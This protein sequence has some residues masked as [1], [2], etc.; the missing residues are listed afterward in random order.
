ML[1]FLVF[2]IE[3]K[4]VCVCVYIYIYYSLRVYVYKINIYVLI[5]CISTLMNL[6]FNSN[7][8]RGYLRISICK[9]MPC[10]NR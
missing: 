10:I 8:F 3:F 7:I 2:E 9:I 6:F 1:K 5:L 4:N